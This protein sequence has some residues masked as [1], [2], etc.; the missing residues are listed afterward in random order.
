MAGSMS[1]LAQQT[2]QSAEQTLK[3]VVVKEKAEA[4]E[5]RDS[6]RA[7][8]TSIGKGKQ[9]LRDIPQ[10]IT[11]VTERLIDDRNLDT[12]KEVLKNTS[13]I[14]FQAAE[15]GEEDIKLRGFSLAATG[16]IFVDGM[17][18]P[19]FYERDTFSL[20]R[21][22]VLRGSASMLFGRGS[23]GGAVNLV[24]KTPHLM[25]ESLVDVTIGSYSH[26]RVVG[27]FNIKTG[28]SAALRINAMSTDAD[29]N[30][31]GSRLD[32]KGVSASYRWGIGE[33][34]EFSASL[35]HLDNHNG[36]NYG[37]PWI[38]PTAAQSTTN[39]MG[40][41]ASATTTLP[42]DPS[43]YYGMSSDYNAGTASYATLSH[44]HRFDDDSELKTQLRQGRY[45]RDQRAG[46]VRL[47][48]GGTNATTGVYAANAACPSVVNANLSNFSNSSVLL[49]G[50]NLKI[51]DM[52]TLY[53]Q[54]DYQTKFK[55]WGLQHELLAGLDIAHE[56]K[57]VYGART[58]AQ[59][60][61]VP[62]K[63][64]TTIGTPNDGASIKEASRVLRT[65]SDYDSS[66]WGAYVQDLVHVAPHWKL[67]AGLRF[68]QLSGDYT[69]YNLSATNVASQSSYQMRVSELS[70]R[71][72]V[73]YQPNTLQS[74][75][76]SAATSFNT[77]GDAYSLGASNADTPPEQSINI[78]LGAKLDSVDKRFTTRLAVFQSTKL[79][80]RNTD[81]TVALVTLSGKRHVVGAEIDF[82]G[83]LTPRWEIYGSYM[84]MPEANIDEGVA[85]SEG[86]GTRPS[87][88]P[89]HS[90][91]IWSTY[92]INAQWRVGAG[93]NFR[94]RQTPI[95]NP[96]WEV[97]AWVTADL[98]AEYQM[99][100][101]FT[102]KAN[103]SNLTNELYADQLYTGH[104]I[105]GAGRIYQLT[106]TFKF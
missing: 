26:K 52:D 75:H 9:Q 71:L 54:S 86:Q 57:T 41:P 64:S 15:G 82:S 35:Y 46:T 17:R 97:P 98:M 12:V 63:P 99:N 23:T 92:Q 2:G 84:W 5:G 50:T 55:A 100:D 106:G 40:S 16:D 94:G 72:G 76:F 79:H 48:Q 81:P 13:G 91:S 56:K 37:M 29:N 47:C 68:D 93:L 24:T 70:K 51:Q 27:D 87:S 88:T 38:R 74:Y 65:T 53:G 104:Y 21:M 11:V 77:S 7:V 49:R 18:D 34:D 42:L 61:V 102:L 90:G 59:G 67:L 33:R 95:R 66:G 58:V 4:P 31:A 8:E 25:D 22:E 1:A 96:G 62:V 101:K 60:G 69:A 28:E 85:G 36:M 30:G 103:V 3:P 6:V 45:T 83:R 73:L 10:S 105:P 14:S 44:L 80:E 43:A 78:E 20:D 39:P 19:A 89:Y 32:K